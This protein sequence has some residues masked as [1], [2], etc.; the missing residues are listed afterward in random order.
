MMWWFG[1]FGAKKNKNPAIERRS[2]VHHI[3]P[4]WPGYLNEHIIMPH[5]DM[6]VHEK[7][8]YQRSGNMMMIFHWNCGYPIFRLSGYPI[9][10][11]LLYSLGTPR[12]GGPPQEP[13]PP[14]KT[15]ESHPGWVGKPMDSG[16]IEPLPKTT[17]KPIISKIEWKATSVH[18]VVCMQIVSKGL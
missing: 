12:N 11:D 8:T 9:Y 13:H 5:P 4:T 14:P 1:N 16:P 10:P 17:M 15:A 7:T 3:Q 18:G 6:F 2:M